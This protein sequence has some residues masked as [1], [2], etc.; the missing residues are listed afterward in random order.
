MAFWGLPTLV[1]IVLVVILGKV[2]G[3]GLADLCGGMIAHLHQFAK[4]LNGRV[5][6]RGVVE[7]NGGEVLRSDVDSLTVNLLEVVD[8]KEIAH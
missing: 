3:H 6:L 5:A 1:Q 7:P 8:F 2:E 4:D